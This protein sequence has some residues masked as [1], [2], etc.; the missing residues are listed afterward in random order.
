M[1]P[2]KYDINNS[3][4]VRAI[5]STCDKGLVKSFWNPIQQFYL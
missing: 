4:T 2:Q 1:G 3:E 5:H